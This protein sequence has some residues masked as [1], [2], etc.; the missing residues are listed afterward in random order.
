MDRIWLEGAAVAA[1][2]ALVI[3]ILLWLR[4]ADRKL[5]KLIQTAEAMEQY[6]Q[7]AAAQ[8]TALMDPVTAT[9]RTVQKQLDGMS[10]V[11]EATKRIGDAANQLSFTVNRVSTDLN[12]TV[13][14]HA[15]KSGE[16]VKHGITE[17]LDWAEVSYAVWQFW[18]N[19]RKDSR[20]SACSS[21]G[22][23]QDTTN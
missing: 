23:G 8:V 7:H 22:Q 5:G 15:A 2:V 20:S 11:A 16:K 17:A 13:E 9:V 21:Y 19:K 18:Q 4:S 6:T 12:E 3:G 1:F 14:R 10:K